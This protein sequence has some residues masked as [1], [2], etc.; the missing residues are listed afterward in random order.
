MASWAFVWLAWLA[1][2]VPARA[3]LAPVD[4]TLFPVPPR[5]ALTFWGHAC[6]YLDVDGFGIVTD[7]VFQSGFTIERRHIPAPPSRSYAGARLIIVSHAHPD[8]LDK[9]TLR[10][11]PQQCVIL[12]PEPSAKYLSGL[13][14]KVQIMRP[15][16]SYA[17]PGGRVVAVAAD[18][19]GGRQ[20][21][22]AAPDGRALGYVIETPGGTLYYAGDSQ[23]FA[24]FDSVATAYHPD[25]ALLNLNGH[26]HS[27]DAV[28][29]FRATGAKRLVPMHF[30]A[31]GYLFLSER[32]RP[33]DFEEIEKL[34][35]PQLVLLLPGQSLALPA[36]TPARKPG[37]QPLARDP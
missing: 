9:E 17:Y 23:Y 24:G 31:Y 25:I 19:P 7:P 11:F 26:L 29:A 36:R 14:Q 22:S 8:H 20:W 5:D 13:P 2:A 4:S 10:S 35:G 27:M 37:E 21:G 30:G 1:L 34:L 18:H 3:G 28:R 32:K 16:G 33:R 12:C 6:C 15:G